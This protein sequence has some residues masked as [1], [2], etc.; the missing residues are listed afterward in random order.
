MQ[1]KG[2]KAKDWHH[3]C[4]GLLPSA[5]TPRKFFRVETSGEST[6][7]AKS[8]L[9]DHIRGRG[10]GECFT[11]VL[12][13]PETPVVKFPEHK[14]ILKYLLCALYGWSRG[15]TK[16]EMLPQSSSCATTVPSSDRRTV[17]WK[18]R[19]L[20][21]SLKCPAEI[22]S[23]WVSALDP[24]QSKRR[25]QNAHGILWRGHMTCSGC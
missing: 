7:L 8:R 10:A 3:F 14:L 12:P 16:P 2:S 1:A 6:W 15:E 4:L 19:Y 22:Q 18:T 11:W 21:T 17:G 9:R 13:S 20:H 5:Q 25:I 24:V 23:H